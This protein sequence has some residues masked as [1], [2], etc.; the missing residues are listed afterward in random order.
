MLPHLTGCVGTQHH[1]ELGVGDQ[2]QPRVV[3]QVGLCEW[4]R[5]GMAAQED[6]RAALVP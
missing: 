6:T 1:P 2:T 4:K 3:S 5:L